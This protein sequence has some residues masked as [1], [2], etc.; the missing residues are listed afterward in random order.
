MEKKVDLLQKGLGEP[1]ETGRNI[2]MSGLILLNLKKCS[3]IQMV[4][5]KSL[6]LLKRGM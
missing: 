3:N 6:L 4:F 5:V 2:S 1:M